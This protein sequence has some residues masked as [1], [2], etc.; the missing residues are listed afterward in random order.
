MLRKRKALSILAVVSSGL[1]AAVTFV[2]NIQLSEIINTVSAGYSPPSRAVLSALLTMLAMGV[3]NY[4]KAYIGGFACESMTHDLRVGYARR[5]SSLPFSEIEMLNA[6]ERLSQLQNEI[7]GVSAYLNSNLFQLFDDCVRFLTTFMWLLFINPT[8]T[9]AS[10]LPA[11]VIVAY[12]FW[13]SKTIGK[14][15]VLSQ[16]AK[17]EMNRFA[18][19]LLALFPVIRLYDA[20][21]MVLTGYET[22]AEQWEAQTILSERLRARLMSISALLTKIPLMLLFLVGGHLAINRALTVGTLYIFLNLSGNVS[23]VLM[24]MPGY[25]ASFRQFSANMKRLEGKICL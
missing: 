6:G 13:S 21:H 2:W 4:A 7:G 3:T 25:I 19:T 1:T 14:A 17:A 20:S 23:G 18:D 11:F 22:A 15:V 10:N 24:N 8:L 9:L 16:Q 5:L 12:V